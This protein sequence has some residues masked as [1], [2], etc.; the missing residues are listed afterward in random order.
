MPETVC[1]LRA[2]WKQLIHER[3]IMANDYEPQPIDTSAV[4]LPADLLELTERLAENTHEVWARQR[5]A[6]GWTHGPERDDA[7]KHHPCLVPY[8]ELSEGEKQYDR[9]TALETLKMI[10]ALGYE[11][12][13]RP[14]TPKRGPRKP[15]PT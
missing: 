15:K 13:K 6:D 8:A 10:L 2:D 1:S 5:I 3:P 7:Q 12:R 14:T 4:E 9:N 11:I